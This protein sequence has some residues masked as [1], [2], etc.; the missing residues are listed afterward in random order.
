[1]P[2]DLNTSPFHWG[3][4]SS[5]FQTEG[6]FNAHNRGAS[7]WDDFTSR[8]FRKP[9]HHSPSESTQFYSRYRDDIDII[10]QLGIP[11]FRFS[12]SWCRILPNGKGIVNQHG[13]DFYKKL[14]DY[15]LESG[16][17]PWITLYHW[18][19]P[20]ALERLGGW[21]NREIIYW[22]QEYTHIIL[23]AL[24]DRVQY[25]MV[26]NEPLAF[27]GA[28]Y[29]LG[30]HAPGRRGFDNFLPAAH[31]AALVQAQGI[32]QIQ[33]HSTGLRAGTTFS[34][35]WISANSHSEKDIHAAQKAD[36][37]LNRFFLEPLLGYGYPVSDLP[38]LKKLYEYFLPG[39]EHRLMASPDFIGV[40]NYTREVVKHSCFTPYLRLRTIHPAKRKVPMTEMN[41]E[42]HPKGL[43]K[44]L[45]KYDAY[46]EIK[47]IIITENGAAF[48]D[49][50]DGNNIHDEKRISYLKH[51][52][53]S[54]LEARTAS[55]KING[56]FVWSLT[57]NFEWTE[58]FR[59]RFGLV[60]IDY[61]TQRRII[62]SSGFWF[63]DYIKGNPE[64]I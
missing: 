26:L 34:C 30:V 29:F 31:H 16:I 23:S 18:D 1:M 53:E 57:D 48:M 13:L 8:K 35:S 4:A 41:W 37:L 63:S 14:T 44:I 56:Y 10:R 62:K 20:A 25:W 6:A 50:L 60:Y 17:Q 11:N 24:A 55:A 22:F 28:G 15:C 64:N 54:V 7:I 2:P 46:P 58:G 61:K 59:P 40:Q 3:I 49:F 52:I 12:V 5:A 33:Q 43:Y 51:Y 36:A 19:L 47:S 9:N 45:M 21:K 42:I 39:D 27:T 32:R 38:F